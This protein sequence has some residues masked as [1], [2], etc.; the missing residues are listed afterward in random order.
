MSR[1][2]LEL[3]EFI[4]EEFLDE[5]RL[6]PMATAAEREW[7]AFDSAYEF[8]HNASVFSFSIM[9]QQTQHVPIGDASGTIQKYDSEFLH[10]IDH[11]QEMADKDPEQDI[12]YLMFKDILV[13]NHRNFL[14][15]VG[16]KTKR[17]FDPIYSNNPVQNRNIARNQASGTAT[18]VKS[19]PPA[20]LP[21]VVP[22]VTPVSRRSDVTIKPSI[23]NSTVLPLNDRK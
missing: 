3:F 4:K 6:R 13:R 12:K 16:G 5:A 2:S 9:P 7:S 19:N 23:L 11:F 8:L 1:T 17:V 14:T 15:A 21:K 20:Q 10:Y 18:F 22:G